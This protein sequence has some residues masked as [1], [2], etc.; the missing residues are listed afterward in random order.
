MQPTGRPGWYLQVCY[1]EKAT[2]T[3]HRPERQHNARSNRRKQ[4]SPNE[5]K[6][7][8]NPTPPRK[9]QTS[10]TNGHTPRRMKP[11]H[12]RLTYTRIRPH[13]PSHQ[14]GDHP[15]PASVWLIKSEREKPHSEETSQHAPTQ[16]PCNQPATA[17]LTHAQ[18][19]AAGLSLSVCIRLFAST[20]VI[21]QYCSSAYNVRSSCRV[22][23]GAASCAEPRGR[24]FSG[25]KF[26]TA[27]T[28]DNQ[29][30]AFS[31]VSAADLHCWMQLICTTDD[32][33]RSG[34]CQCQ[35][36]ATDP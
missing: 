14:A 15:E 29:V 22:P 36:A 2:P 5:T 27:L 32:A 33:V 10:P 23:V 13:A 21:K 20:T 35:R 28:L 30:L 3:R 12:T 31:S 17:V 25:R 11:T 16:T 19:G 9:R 6:P 34:R 4:C 24:R 8:A 26:T 18:C 1:N 7:Y